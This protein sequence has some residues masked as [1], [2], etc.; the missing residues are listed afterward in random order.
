MRDYRD[1]VHGDLAITGIVAA[2][3]DSRGTE[4][5]NADLLHRSCE[6]LKRSDILDESTMMK[7]AQDCS[8]GG[9]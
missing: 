4:P 3:G 7:M 6:Y 5:T 1:I 9:M 2:C 8:L